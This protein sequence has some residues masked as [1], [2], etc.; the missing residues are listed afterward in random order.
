M[1]ESPSQIKFDM[2]KD[3]GILD[4]VLKHKWF[5]MIESG[6]KKEEYREIKPYYENRFS[7]YSYRVVR[8]HRGYSDVTMNWKIKYIKRAI[9]NP[10]WGAPD[11]PVFVIGLQET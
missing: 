3:D 8:F 4:L 6:E 2:A 7:K 9:G 1:G 5:D 11:Y 10:N